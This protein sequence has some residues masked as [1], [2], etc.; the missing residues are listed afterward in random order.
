MG[1]LRKL[2]IASI[3]L[4]IL[5][6]IG[7]SVVPAMGHD[8]DQLLAAATGWQEGY[9]LVLTGNTDIAS[10]NQARDYVI[11]QGGRIAILSPPHAMLGWISPELA[12][13][14]IGKHGIEQV[15]FS[16]VDLGKIKYQ[17]EQTMAV[18]NFFNA[19]A[20]GSLRQEMSGIIETVGTPLVNDALDHPPLNFEKYQENLEGLGIAASPGNSDSM[21]GSVAVCLFFVESNGS[22]DPNSYTWTQTDVQNTINRAVSGLN[23]LSSEATS[24]G[25]SVT[26]TVHYYSP[27]SPFTQQGYEPILHSHSDD[28]LWIEQIMDNLNFT[29]GDIFTRVTAFNTWLKNLY[30]TD[31]AYSVF[32]AY[33]PSPAPTTFSDGWLSYAYKGGPY[34]QTLFSTDNWGEAN[35]GR[36]LSHETGH[37]FWACDEYSG[38]GTPCS[39]CGPCAPNGPRPTANNGNCQT[40]NPN[41]VPC[42]MRHNE[43]AVCPFTAQ[44][45]GL[46]IIKSFIYVAQD[47]QCGAK[48]P[49]F[50]TIQNGIESANNGAIIKITEETYNENV[51]LNSA[52]ELTLQ[53]GWDFTFTTNVSNTTIN[54]SLTISDGELIIENLILE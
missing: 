18:V 52:K 13:Q 47:G 38:A 49:C 39:S 22:I 21:T 23:W 24:Y 33:N 30:S 54:G 3:V 40:C 25:A 6:T 46:G 8:R 17:D 1:H 41:S 26:F 50:T 43:Y 31:W 7:A 29:S 48:S 2:K 44:Q 11:S 35:F 14:I 45:I 12:Q 9:T 34:V 42:I 4:G 51:V 36:V 5:L 10:A 32:I 15:F 37:I 27:T 20:S 53:G 16:P 28:H 19:V